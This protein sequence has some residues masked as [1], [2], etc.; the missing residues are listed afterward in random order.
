MALL[1]FSGFR[2]VFAENVDG[3]ECAF[4]TYQPFTFWTNGSSD[5]VYKKSLCNGEGQVVHDPGNNVGDQ[6][7]RCDYL[8]GYNFV[9][10]PKNA[11]TCSPSEEDCSCYKMSC[12]QGQLLTPGKLLYF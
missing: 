10:K 3:I 5:C 4:D 1:N 8:Q 12:P 11:C 6:Q 9:I 7:C 2:K